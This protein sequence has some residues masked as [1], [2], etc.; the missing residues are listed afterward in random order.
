[1]N[2]IH[3]PADWQL[4][5]HSEIDQVYFK[6]L[7][8]LYENAYKSHKV[9]PPKELVFNALKLC[10]LKQ[11]KVIIIGQDPYHGENQANGLSFSVN[12]GVKKPPSLQNVFKEMK[13]DLLNFEIPD[14]GNLENWSKEG[15]L[16]L[17]AMLS[18][19]EAKPG[20]HKSFGW[21]RFTNA[22]IK[23]L[24]DS[25]EHLVFLLWGKYAIAK[26]ELINEEKHLILCA[27]HP[28]PLARGAFFGNK[29]FS[30]TNA[31]LKENGIKDINWNL[32]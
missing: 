26:K 11:V 22:L 13:T 32:T 20:S 14:S 12:T 19:E 2:F 25:K 29:H 30:K 10:P 1:M 5:L 23:N 16:L 9:Y 8:R 28:S 6:E 18:V 31:Y 21:E 17:N 15:V 3:L 7:L 27:A 24:S 4:L